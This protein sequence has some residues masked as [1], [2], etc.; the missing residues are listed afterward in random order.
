MNSQLID[1]GLRLGLHG[2][3]AV[4]YANVLNIPWRKAK[5]QFRRETDMLSQLPTLVLGIL[6]SYPRTG[7]EI[8][9]ILWEE[10]GKRY[11]ADQVVAAMHQ[12]EGVVKGLRGGKVVFSCPYDD[13][14][15]T[16]PEAEQLS[17]W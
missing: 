12:I 15:D 4:A 8:A 14:D 7:Q 17:L 10:T 1:C 3:T 11:R 2:S 6:D 16:P 5:D 13:E 9:L